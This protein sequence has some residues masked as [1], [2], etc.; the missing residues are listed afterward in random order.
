[1]LT[2]PTRCFEERLVAG[3]ILAVIGD[4]RLDTGV[5]EVREVSGG[6]VRLGLSADRVEVVVDAWSHV[7]V[8][9]DWILKE[10]PEHLIDLDDFW[11]CR[12]PVTNQEYLRFLLDTDATARPSTWQ[13][14]AYPWDR[15]NH[16]VAGVAAEDADHYARWFSDRTGHPWRLPSEPEWEHAAKGFECYE[17]PW[18]DKFEPGRANTRELRV[19][20]TT[21]VGMFPSGASPFGLLDMAG[22]VEEYVADDY[23]PYPGGQRVRDHLVES[24]GTYRVAR[25]G[26]F[27]RYGDLA[28]TRRRHGGFPSPLYPI[29]FR[30][31][32]SDA[33]ATDVNDGK[34]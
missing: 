11:L 19:N 1:M 13:L 14:G 9:A 3:A 4:P 2:D 16:P 27:A 17:Y 24:R 20:T 30:L 26:S 34:A 21:P 23:A 10:V 7:G 15:S 18:G 25:G 32:T 8:E 12:L 6:R 28:R 31:A 5:P 29:G 22:N 33:P